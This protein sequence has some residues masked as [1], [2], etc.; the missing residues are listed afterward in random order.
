MSDLVQN[1]KNEKFFLDARLEEMISITAFR[2]V[3][4]N[5]HKLIVFVPREHWGNEKLYLNV[6]DVVNVSM[7]P[8]DMSRGEVVL[9]QGISNEG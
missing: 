3:L 2:A 5:G 4:Q 7:S 6:G 9:D 1:E 8:F